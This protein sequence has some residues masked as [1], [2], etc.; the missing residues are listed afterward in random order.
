MIDRT[1]SEVGLPPNEFVVGRSGLDRRFYRLGE[2]GSTLAKLRSGTGMSPRSRRLISDLRLME[3]L[4]ARGQVSFRT[5][6]SPPETYYLM[7]NA[8]GLAV[9]DGRLVTRDV[10]KMHGLPSS[11]L[12]PPA[13]ARRLDDAVH[14]LLGPERNGGAC[15]GH[16]SA[17]ESLADLVSRSLDLVTFRFLV[18]L[19]DMHSMSKRAGGSLTTRRAGINLSDLVGREVGLTVGATEK[20][21]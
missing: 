6:G 3:E 4:A 20:G 8:T 11:R 16:W 12:P 9:D 19:D 13:P 10:H 5:E 14:Y 7:L 17:S 21:A 18:N 15:I 2:P 1:A